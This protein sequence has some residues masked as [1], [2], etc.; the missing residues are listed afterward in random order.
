MN[1]PL[2]A[3]ANV[4]AAAFQRK[5]DELDLAATR[6]QLTVQL[7]D[8]M[9]LHALSARLSNSLELPKVLEE[10]LASVTELQGADRGVLMLRDRGRD[11]MVTAASVGFTLGELDATE[12]AAVEAAPSETITAIISGGLLVP[13]A[14]TDPILVPHQA[15]RCRFAAGCHAACS[16]PLLTSG[17]AADRHHCHPTSPGS[18]P[19]TDRETRLVELYARQAAEFIDNAATCIA[20]SARQTGTRTSSWRCWRTSFATHSRP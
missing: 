18:A 9:R 3:V 11:S 4:L 14:G 5:R 16:T 6:D 19:S 15:K 13:D 8:L 7:A 2:Q 17:G 10:V 1:F 12:E 20:R